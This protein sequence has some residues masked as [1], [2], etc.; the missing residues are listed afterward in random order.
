MKLFFTLEY[1]F[2]KNVGTM[3]LNR[4]NGASVSAF[5]SPHHLFLHYE[6]SVRG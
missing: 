3:S 4:V 5:P 2:Q 6:T 1:Q